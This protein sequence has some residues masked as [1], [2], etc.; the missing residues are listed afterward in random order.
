MLSRAAHVIFLGVKVI[1]LLS[2]IAI[3]WFKL[4]G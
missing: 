3:C 1:F 4:I 2:L